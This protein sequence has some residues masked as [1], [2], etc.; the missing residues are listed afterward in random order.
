MDQVKV[1]LG[2]AKKHHFWILAVIVVI[3]SIV[4]W[5][6]A[7]SSLAARYTADKQAIDAAKKGL[8]ETQRSP[9]LANPLFTK[10]VDDLHDNL[11]K[12]VFAAW[13]KLYQRQAEL[14]KWPDLDVGG[15]TP[16]NIGLRLKPTD[17]IPSNYRSI[18]NEAVLVDQ[19]K[20]LF[21]Q[22]RIRRPVAPEKDEDSEDQP[23]AGISSG[24]INYEGV[25]VWDEELRQAIIDR[26]YTDGVPSSAKL[27]LAQEDYWLFQSLIWIINNVNGD[28]SD[29]LKAKIKE[30]QDLDVAQWAIAAAQTSAKDGGKPSGRRR[31]GGGTGGSMGMGGPMGPGGGMG[32]PMGPGGSMGGPMG[33][34]GSMGGPMGPGGPSG[35]NAPM[36]PPSAGGANP[37]TAAAGADGAKDAD[38]ALRDGRYLDEKGQPLSAGAQEPFAEFKQV[39]VYFKLTMDQRAVPELIASCANAPLPVETRQVTF[40]ILDDGESTSGMGMPVFGGQ[41]GGVETLANDAT[42]ELSG[43]IYLYNPPDPAQLGMG[44]AG[45]PAQR[46]FGVPSQA[47]AVPGRGKR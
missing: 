20:R 33:P 2:V 11:K 47:V 32:G 6:M 16:Y 13:E 31:T 21:D 41:P 39:F 18:Y 5:M 15:D 42:I 45:S 26:Y 22:L 46:S 27:R 40:T 8:E 38:S 44:K 19:W 37:Q 17:D 23:V 7:A 25:I 30:I 3:V 34:G 29:P 12:E 14:L 9:E 36:P 10:K 28:A 24:P 43:V 4:V 1:Y 35:N